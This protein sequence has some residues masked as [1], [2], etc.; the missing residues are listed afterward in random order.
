[1]KAKH[2]DPA[3]VSANAQPNSRQERSGV[4]QVDAESEA[5]AESST[6]PNQKNQPKLSFGEV[7]M[8]W[9]LSRR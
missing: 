5:P 7:L 1:M 3:I 6:T 2:I 4:R 9:V 8:L